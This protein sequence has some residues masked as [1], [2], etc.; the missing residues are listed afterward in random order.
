MFKMSFFLAH[1]IYV[2]HIL[3]KNIITNNMSIKNIDNLSVNMSIKKFGQSIK[4]MSLIIHT[5]IIREILQHTLHK[6]HVCILYTLK[7]I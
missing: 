6:L 7:T 1:P 3:R 2:Q 4:T 5:C